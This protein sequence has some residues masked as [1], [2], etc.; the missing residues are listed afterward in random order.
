MN[1]GWRL[2]L[3]QFWAM[4]L[5]RVTDSYRSKMTILVQ[6]C[7]PVI[8]TIIGIT[9]KYLIQV[10]KTQPSLVIGYG[11]YQSPLAPFKGMYRIR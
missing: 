8:L 11:G 6:L 7:V 3:Q 2:W 1:T 4:F 5:K 10:G 9:V